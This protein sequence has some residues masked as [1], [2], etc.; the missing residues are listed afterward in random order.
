[1]RKKFCFVTLIFILTLSLLLTACQPSSENTSTTQVDE[2]EEVAPVEESEEAEPAEAVEEVNQVEDVEETE[3]VVSKEEP[4]KI[5]GVY[6]M[7]ISEEPDTLDPHKSAAAVSASIL[8]YIGDPLIYKGLNNDYIPGLA[9]S[10]DVSED[11]LVW[12]FELRQDVKFHDGTALDAEAVVN[13]FERALSPEIASPI[14]GSLLGEVEKMET[15]DNYSFSIYLLQPNADFEENL[16]DTGRLLILSPSALEEFGDDIARSPVSTGPW[17]FKEWV[18]AS[19]ITLVRNPDYNWGPEYAHEGPVYIE[20]IQFSIIGE[21]AT[22]QAAFENEE[23]DSLSISPSD[24]AWITETGDYQIFSYHRKGVGLFVEF[25]VTK[26]PFDDITVRKAF[27][28]A[29]NKQSAV[30][31]ALEGYGEKAYGPLA[32]TIRGYWDGIE[33]YAPDYDPEMA[34]QLLDEAGWLLNESTGLREKDGKPFAFEIFTAPIDTWISTL[35]LIQDDLAVLGITMEIQTYEFGTLLEKTKAGEQSAH[36]MGYTY[37]T[38]GILQLWFHSDNIGTGLTLSH[39]NDPELDEMI[40][41]SLVMVDWDARKELLKN[42]QIKIVDDALWVP[43][44][45]NDSY[46]AV[47]PWVKDVKM[48]PDAYL[49]LNDAYLEN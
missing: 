15:I 26:A 33:E 10:W 12:T 30:D 9:T 17:M 23:L 6:R 1:M 44:W 2:G 14:A 32:P 4:S 8:K 24:V 5:G 39:N 42:I 7:Q 25:N 27:N 37:S 11:G 35:Q 34:A 46:I 47:Q 3:E 36:V 40:D 38:P 22:A 48:H 16:T 19:S 43:V 18:S 49:I 31:I 28:Y 13:T 20:E 29:I 21:S 45:S 41:E